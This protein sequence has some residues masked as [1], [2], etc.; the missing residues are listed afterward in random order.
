MT[1]VSLT[2]SAAS[3][4]AGTLPF[5]N[6]PVCDLEQLRGPWQAYYHP[7]AQGTLPPLK[8]PG[9][10]LLQTKVQRFLMQNILK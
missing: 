1:L 2:V 10:H 6:H 8:G 5:H 7:P 4:A 9:H 3:Q